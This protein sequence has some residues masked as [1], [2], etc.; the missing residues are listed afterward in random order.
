MKTHL[1]R[2]VNSL[3]LACA[4]AGGCGWAG[5][6]WAAPAGKDLANKIDLSPVNPTAVVPP[7]QG[8]G[9]RATAGKIISLKTTAGETSAPEANDPPDDRAGKTS[10]D[11]SADKG[12]DKIPKKPLENTLEKPPADRSDRSSTGAKTSTDE[13]ADAA[14]AALMNFIIPVP[15][16][17]VTAVLDASKNRETVLRDG[18]EA[19][20]IKFPKGSKIRLDAGH[21]TLHLTLPHQEVLHLGQLIS[22]CQDPPE[23]TTALQYA[24]SLFDFQD[25]TPDSCD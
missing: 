9:I 25:H 12:S 8:A 14:T 5:T 20:G 6:A 10:Q 1:R 23:G 13:A 22:F 17:F 4:I 24:E 3:L 21:K 18:L 11:R 19:Q 16:V 7:D 2:R 15:S